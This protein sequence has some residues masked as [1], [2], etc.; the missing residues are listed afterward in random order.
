MGGGV[1]RKS[2]GSDHDDD[3]DGKPKGKK[4]KKDK[5]LPSMI[6]NKE[7][8]NEV[9]SKLKR[10][11]R[12]EKR[13]QAKAREVAIQRALELGEEVFSLSLSFFIFWLGFVPGVIN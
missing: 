5:T 13:K 11:K 10:E 7:K 12:I 3:V 9:Y 2:A 1:K 8:R 6:K 4:I